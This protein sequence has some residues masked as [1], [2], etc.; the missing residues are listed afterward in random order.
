MTFSPAFVFLNSA[1]VLPGLALVAI[2]IIIH[3]INRLRYRRVRFAA[4]EFLLASEERNRRR[5]LLEQLL[6]LLLRILLILLIVALL[7]RLMLSASQLSLFQGA[8]SHHLVVLDDSGSMRDR[9][10][11][12]TAFDEARA[13]IRKLVAEGANQPGTQKFTLILASRPDDTPSGMSE[14]TI[15]AAFLDEVDRRLDDLEC[16]HQ[17]PDLLRAIQAAQS[18]LS[19][20]PTDL[21]HLHV[22]SD[23]RT[24]EWFDNKALA[25][26]LKD[27]DDAGVAVNLVRTVDAQHQNVAITDLTGS[28]EVAAAGIPVSLQV[29]VANYGSRLAEDVRVGLSVD[30][31]A[32]PMNLVFETIEPETEV[33]RSFELTFD[34]AGAHRVEVALVGDALEQDNTRHLAVLVPEENPVLIIDGAPGGEQGIYIADA[35]AADTSVTGFTTIVDGP[36]YLRKFPLDRFHLI[37]MVNVPELQPDGLAALEQFVEGGGGLAWFLGDAVIPAYYNDQLVKESGGL[38]PAPLGTAPLSLP[39]DP[40]ETAGPDIAPTSHP[41]FRILS[42]SDNPFVDVVFVN[43]YYPLADS[44]NP[45]EHPDVELVAELRNGRPLMLEHRFGAGRIITCLTSAGPL[46]GPDGQPWTNWAN[47]P[48]APS[49]AVLQ[50]DLAKSIARRDRALPQQMVGEPLRETVVASLYEGEV[51][52][53]SPDRRVTQIQVEQPAGDDEATVQFPE[54]DAPGIYGVRLVTK[55]REQIEKLIAVNVP[56]SEGRL[57]LATDEQ[58]HQSVGATTQLTIQP[59]G[60]F[61]WIRSRAPGADVRWWLLFLLVVF[62]VCEQALACRLSFHHS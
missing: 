34:S 55:G 50:L 11:D 54:T 35:L 2:P 4:M 33:E 56:Q 27:L 5:I 62:G 31:R 25:D 58:I 10:G 45:T 53:V 49:F 17:S 59:P 61:D 48:G 40:T 41:L 21:K 18:R 37:Y 9:V 36:D 13:V 39:R 44:W 6:L 43:H 19:D 60:R 51:E 16:T 47:G 29:S 8:Q 23:F 30:G 38:F 46:R 57:E 26:V 32:V 52:F 12:S 1:Y 24:Q 7:G 28:V 20:D 42:G 3:L 14:R 15:D 22:I